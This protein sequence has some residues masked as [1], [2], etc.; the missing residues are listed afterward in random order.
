VFTLDPTPAQERLLR[1]YCGAARFSYNWALNQVTHNMNVRRLERDAG[2]AEEELTPA[3][4]WSKFSL[5]KQFNG[6]KRNAAPW[7]PEVSKH[8]FDTGINQA[9]AALSNWSDSRAGKRAGAPVG[10]PRHKSRH[11]SL[12]SVS[13]VEL[14]H[15][16]SW[17]HDSRHGVR[18]ML[19][20]SKT[21]EAHRRAKQLAWIHTVSST[22]RLYRLVEAKKATIQK[23][24][25]SYRGG[26]WQVSFQVRY[27]LAHR[28]VVKPVRRLGRV[29]GV[30]M[31]I[32]HLATLSHPIPGVTD[33]NGHVPNPCVL[34]KHLDRLRR[35]DRQIARCQ[36]G[37]NNR[38]RLLHRRAR[39]H[40]T[41]TKTRA[42]HLHRLANVLA[43]GFDI[44]GIEDLN[45]KDLSRR[46]NRL[47]RQ[48]ADVSLGELRRILTY[49]TVD[50][51]T[52]L[53][54]VGRFYP[55]SKTCS[56]C[57]AV[58]AKLTLQ[59]RTFNCNNCGASIDRDVNAA[60]NIA[61]EAIRLHELT[62]AS[63]EAEVVAGLRPETRNADSRL[64]QTNPEHA[65]EAA[66]DHSPR[67]SR[68]EPHNTTLLTL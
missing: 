2:V 46:D 14:N 61:R 43:G 4:L 68:A 47:G 16:L 28:P 24:T 48:L 17:L 60:H 23:A 63:T 59:Q 45:V 12:L 5:G 36:P 3:L 9:A 32:T 53:V 6:C 34:D 49:T 54:A 39:L 38:T 56:C 22:R 19:P 40:G 27:K 58:T 51:G 33:S 44:V 7:W 52:A 64:C 20:Q 37:S 55:S 57:G 25:F 1:S 13:F 35:L 21:C 62:A 18:L 15:Q 11:R 26:R 42:L 67:E 30:D 41:I 8:A 50:R 65:L 29:I 31:G 66:A 10:F